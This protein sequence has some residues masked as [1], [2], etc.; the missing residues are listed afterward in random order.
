MVLHAPLTLADLRMP[1]RSRGILLNPRKSVFGVAL[2]PSPRLLAS[3]VER[4][5]NLNILLARRCQQDDPGS[6]HK[7]SRGLSAAHQALKFLL[8]LGIQLDFCS[9]AHRRILAILA[10]VTRLMATYTRGK[11]VRCGRCATYKSYQQ[12]KLNWRNRRSRW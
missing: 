11:T 8:L 4:L 6:L 2:S 5:A 7:P 9:D 1:S 3:D 10:Y 12:L